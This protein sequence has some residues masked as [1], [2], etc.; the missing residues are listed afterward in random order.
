MSSNANM[1]A[2]T[3][4]VLGVVS[5]VGTWVA[6]AGT[7]DMLA[8]TTFNGGQGIFLFNLVD[9]PTEARIL[10]YTGFGLVAGC[11]IVNAL[12]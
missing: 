7:A 11:A 12:L 10:S 2:T 9:R 1:I 6:I 3:K 4:T 8:P 5:T